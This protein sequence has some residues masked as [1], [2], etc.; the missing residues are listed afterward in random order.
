MN[1]RLEWE[2]TLGGG[3]RLF[4]EQWKPLASYLVGRV[5]T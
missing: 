1:K 2:R 4:R 5:V 3:V